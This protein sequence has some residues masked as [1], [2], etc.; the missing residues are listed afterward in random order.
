MKHIDTHF[1]SIVIS[2]LLVA[3]AVGIVFGIR[4]SLSQHSSVGE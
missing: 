3:M 4:F 2:L 1:R